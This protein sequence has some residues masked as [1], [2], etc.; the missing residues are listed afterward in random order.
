MK[1]ASQPKS[2]AGVHIVPVAYEDDHFAAVI[3]PQGMLTVRMG[4]VQAPGPA[5]SSCIKHTLT[6]PRIA[7]VCT[8]SSINKQPQVSKPVLLHCAD[9]PLCPEFL[10]STVC[11]STTQH[12]STIAR[13]HC[14]FS[15]STA[16]P[17]DRRCT[18]WV[19][20]GGS[21][22]SNKQLSV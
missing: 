6:M 10:L 17:T 13:L 20:C 9:S 21:H 15:F 14:H 2:T 19:Q 3:K 7:G 1:A 11:L 16:L 18:R 8:A 12:A 22:A 5:L 4:S